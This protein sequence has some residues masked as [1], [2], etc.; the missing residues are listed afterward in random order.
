MLPIVVWS[1][2]SYSVPLRGSQSCSLALDANT[3]FPCISVL[4]PL[5]ISVSFVWFA[6]ML[7][8]KM[9]P[10]SNYFEINPLQHLDPSV[11]PRV[12]GPTE[13]CT[14]WWQLQSST[15]NN[16][17]W[18]GMLCPLPPVGREGGER[19]PDTTLPLLYSSPPLLWDALQP[20]S[21][22]WEEQSS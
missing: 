1:L 4:Q 19:T 7:S 13:V 8:D 10:R 22:S 9:V 18:L 20:F 2:F 17:K 12:R 21:A 16:W 15:R 14:K 11:T 3:I 5:T 6:D